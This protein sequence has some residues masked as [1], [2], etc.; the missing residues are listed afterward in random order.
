MNSASS[1][2]IAR[3]IPREGVLLEFGAVAQTRVEIHKRFRTLPKSS[4]WQVVSA[5]SSEGGARRSRK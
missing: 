2:S 4:G 1:S 5:S 3:R